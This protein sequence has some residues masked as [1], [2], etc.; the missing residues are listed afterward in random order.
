MLPLALQHRAT[1]LVDRDRFDL[2]L[3]AAEEGYQ[4]A[5]DTGRAWATSWHLATVATCAGSAAAR[6]PPR[7]CAQRLTC[8]TSSGRGHEK[9]ALLRSCAP[10]A[11]PPC[12]RGLSALGRLIPQEQHIARP[13]ISPMRTG[14]GSRDRRGM[15]PYT[16]S[17]LGGGK[18]LTRI[19]I[20]DDHEIS[21]AALRALLRTE[22]IDVADVGTGDAAITAAIAFHPPRDNRRRD[23]RR[24]RRVPPRPP[25]PGAAARPPPSC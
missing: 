6:K 7:T 13:A 10:P 18:Q 11:R 1:A 5:L 22:G 12:T 21:R 2:A 8:S 3:A 25:T 23:T 9:I 20:V 16:A 4:L 17:A 19:L 24:S 15:Q 14:P